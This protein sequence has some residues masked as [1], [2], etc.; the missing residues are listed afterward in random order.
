MTPITDLNL[1][2]E[3]VPSALVA[4]LAEPYSSTGLEGCAAIET[5][6]AQLDSALGPDMDVQATDADRLSTGRVAK[7]LVASFIPFRGL[8][9]EISGAAEQE[10]NWQAAIYAG[11]VRRGFLKGLGQQKGCNY[12]ARPAFARVI[13]SDSA[14]VDD[15]A[16]KPAESGAAANA[17]LSHEV[18]QPLPAAKR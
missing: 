2:K 8:L 11:S 6:I 15:R 12:P 17:N 3:R 1:S 14:E 5:A 10:R 9:R 13:V 16:A 18:V 4:A 7:S